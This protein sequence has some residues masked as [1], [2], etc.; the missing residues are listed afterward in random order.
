MET[1]PRA[2]VRGIR[3]LSAAV[4]SYV[5]LPI[6]LAIAPTSARAQVGFDRPGGDYI[7][8]PMRSGDPAQCAARCERDARCR[9]WGF[10]YP[11]T[12]SANAMCWLKSKVTP[13]VQS[14]CCASGVRGAGVIEPKTGAVEFGFDRFGGDLRHFETATDASGKSLSARMRSRSQ[15]PRLDVCAARVCRHLGGLLSQEPHHPSAAQALLH[16]RGGQMITRPLVR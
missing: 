11:A 16:F 2:G 3:L 12:E 8:F 9:A 1:E 6:A 10:S 13:R 4:W 5:I 14:A 7:S 15:L